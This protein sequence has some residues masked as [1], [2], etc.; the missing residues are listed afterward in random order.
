M[1]S[2]INPVLALL[3]AA[4]IGVSLWSLRTKNNQAEALSG[5]DSTGVERT[6][7]PS[8]ASRI[9]ESAIAN[10]PAPQLVPTAIRQ[11]EALTETLPSGGQWHPGAPATAIV[12]V[13]GRKTPTL[14]LNQA[15]EFPRVYITPKQEVTVTVALPKADVGSRVVASL[16][17]GGELAEGRPVNVMTVGSEREVSFRFKAG[18]A[19]GRYRV[20]LRHAGESKVVVLWAALDQKTA[21]N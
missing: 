15:G 5:S 9:D 16:E 12:E 7:A 2:K 21:A 11:A 14:Y 4:L 10:S 13:A 1:K 19:A 8:D 20:V 3:L 6:D 18:G 17:D